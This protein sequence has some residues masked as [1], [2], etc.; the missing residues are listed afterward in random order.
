MAWRTA[1]E[2]TKRR[3]RDLSRLQP[4]AIC[5]DSCGRL[6]KGPSNGWKR[7][8][9]RNMKGAGIG[10]RSKLTCLRYGRGLDL[11]FERREPILSLGDSAQER[12][13]SVGGSDG[14]I[15]FFCF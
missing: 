15:S 5:G 4:H 7:R 8:G 11:T 14:V 2:S 10:Y 13:A 9:G 6:E 12:L 1:R 3:Q